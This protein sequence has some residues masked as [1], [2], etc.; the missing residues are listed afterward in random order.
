ME[1]NA[2]VV[3]YYIYDICDCNVYVFNVSIV[4]C[5]YVHVP[6]LSIEKTTIYHIVTRVGNNG[7]ELSSHMYINVYDCY[8]SRLGIAI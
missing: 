6:S 1:H 5:T 3:L 2:A 8:L 4:Q 7:L